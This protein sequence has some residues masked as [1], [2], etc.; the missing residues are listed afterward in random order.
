MENIDLNRFTA[1]SVA[2]FRSVL[3]AA[4]AMVNDPD[5]SEDD[6]A[7]V[8]A[9]G[10]ELQN[11]YDRLE[12]KDTTVHHGSH[13]SG[14]NSKDRYENPATAT[15]VAIPSTIQGTTTS[16]VRSVVSD[17]TLPF[18]LKRGSAYCFKMTVT[19]GSTAVPSFTVGDGTVFQTQFVAKVGN[20]YYFRIWSVG[21]PGQSAGIYTQ[22][23]GEMPQRHCV[24]TVA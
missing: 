18:S 7:A 10:E 16:T 13:S 6:Q 8:D 12:K 24:V 3:E 11:A 17:T 4:K 22:M 1:Q 23:P 9:M 19:N 20:D 15:A 5:L 2:A 14:S 21:A